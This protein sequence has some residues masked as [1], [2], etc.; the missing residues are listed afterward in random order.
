MPESKGSHT[1]KPV[2]SEHC[3]DGTWQGDFDEEEVGVSRLES[4]R[5]PGRLLWLAPEG[6]HSKLR[7]REVYKI[8]FRGRTGGVSVWIY[9]GEDGEIRN[10]DIE[11]G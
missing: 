1:I 2:L 5:P 4:V 11:P 6:G 10:R 3:F 9:S 8:E 7:G